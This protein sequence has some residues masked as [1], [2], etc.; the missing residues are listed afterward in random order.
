MGILRVESCFF[1]DISNPEIPIGSHR[2]MA[3]T[4]QDLL[5]FFRFQGAQLIFTQTI[6][7]VLV[8]LKFV[9]IRGDGSKK[10]PG[11]WCRISC[12]CFFLLDLLK[13]LGQ[14]QDIFSQMVV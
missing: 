7:P 10:P 1:L 2:P 12:G 11:V 9:W 6:A 4:F 8:A 14:K 3:R 5:H 13:M